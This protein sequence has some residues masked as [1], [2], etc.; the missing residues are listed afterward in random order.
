VFEQTPSG[1]LAA[2]PLGEPPHATAP[3]LSLVCR[4]LLLLAG[5]GFSVGLAVGFLLL[6][7]PGDQYFIANVL[8]Q[9][10]RAIVLGCA[11]LGLLLA[12]LAGIGFAFWQ[13][14][15]PDAPARLQH[16]AR[17]LA[18]LGVTAFLPTLWHWALWQGH[19]LLFLTLVVLA[20]LIF[21]AGL[22][23]ALRAGPLAAE[24]R[25]WLR[26]HG[27]WTLAAARR[28]RLAHHL[29]LMVVATGALGYAIYFGYYTCAFHWG[30]RSSFDLGLE[31]NLMWNLLRG[32][33]FKAAPIFGP[34]GSHFGNHATLFSYVLLPI[35]ALYQHCETL[36]VVQA[37]LLGAAAIPLFL[38]ARR[39]LDAKIAALLALLYLLYAPLHGA[40]LFEFHYLP[41]GTFFLWTALWALEARKNV[42]AVIAVVLTLS[43][44]E[45]VAAGL[46]IW[47]AYL[48]LSGHRP[49][50]GLAL[51]ALGGA[52]FVTMKMFVMPHI[53]VGG[54]QTFTDMFQR[55]LP[56]GEDSFG[57][58]LKT[59]VGN[60]VYTLGTLLEAGKLTYLMLLLV[61]LAWLPLR[62][63]W[64]LLFMVPGFLFTLISTGYGPLISMHFQY[65][66]NWTPYLFVAVVLV[67]AASGP[68]QRHAALG[69]LVL[70]MLAT[71][72][73]YGGILQQNTSWGGPIPYRFGI[74]DQ[75][76]LR[77]HA[78][79]EIMRSLPARAK[80]TGSGFVTPQISSRP[81]A[82]SL[83]LG[84][85]DT[86][87]ILC[88]SERA[89]FIGDELQKVT[90]LLEDRSFGVVT[91]V[92]PFA[93]LQHG[94][95]T[96]GNAAL[97]ARWQ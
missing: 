21:E 97:V 93:L 43:V 18:P 19:E 31:N 32:K 64:G 2:R 69:A 22:R 46:S 65:T 1:R 11:A 63:P 50:I 59:V 37:T 33:F 23:V 84:L 16:V 55:L 73:Q 88:P 20:A 24:A 10:A 66:A 52:Y 48:L 39:H 82:Y 74:N 79:D 41:L 70:A 54:H 17:R 80:V 61:P 92:P 89:D 14:R 78:M 6:A 76:R 87:Y 94:H 35:Y 95:D 45:D 25:L 85:Y 4:A 40:N 86:E 5:V 49:R 91:V 30:V 9:R 7:G 67:L 8:G 68:V 53:A 42:L 81:D 27:R 72:Y 47:G 58:V 29:P 90:G 60:P 57:A 28:P 38:F 34:T 75:D 3:W 51:T 36:L 13:R 96:G 71:S 15:A 83:T 12:V 62:R 77:R 26:I 44:R 56:A